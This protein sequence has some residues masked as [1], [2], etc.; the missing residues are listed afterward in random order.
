MALPFSCRQIVC[1]I[2]ISNA[3]ARFLSSAGGGAPFSKSVSG[4]RKQPSRPSGNELS[5]N[6]LDTGRG[7]R[8]VQNETVVSSGG[9]NIINVSGGAGNTVT[10]QGT[11]T[12]TLNIS[13][14]YSAA[15]ITKSKG[16]TNLK[17]TDGEVVNVTGIHQAVF[18]GTVHSLDTSSQVTQL[19]QAMASFGASSGAANSLNTVALN[20]DISQQLLT[21]P[22]QHA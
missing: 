11:A 22:H 16:V 1:G 20:A 21:I 8:L 18:D 14:D 15:T 9:Y 13:Q 12:D 2:L 6:F 17:F 7:L 5:N 10:I 19:V 4:V 3:K